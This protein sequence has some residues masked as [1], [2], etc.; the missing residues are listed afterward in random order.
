MWLLLIS[1]VLGI[2]VTI[3]GEVNRAMGRSPEVWGRA[4]VLKY[5][6]GA[7]L[8]AIQTLPLLS[9]LLRKLKVH[10]AAWLVRSAVAAHVVFLAQAIWQTA[11]GRGRL[12]VG[13]VSFV[14]LV[15][16]A[17]LLSFPVI[18]I[19]LRT[20]ELAKVYRYATKSPPIPVQFQ[21]KV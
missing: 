9:W 7:V 4:G 11:A 3:G 2:L 5:P 20:R 17:I 13:T 16:T 19:L 12:D 10:N 1:C 21:E 18:A 6:H 15:A 8:H 14:G